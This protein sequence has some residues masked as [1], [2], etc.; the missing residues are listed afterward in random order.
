MTLSEEDRRLVGL[1]AAD[2]AER[3]LPLFEAKAPSDTRPRE[4]IEG[5]RAYAR[6]G[7]R[8]AQL[9]SF[10][11]AAHAAAREVDDP[12]ATAAARAASLAAAT[13][14][15]HAL[16]TPHQAKHALG[17][18]VYGAR[19]RELAAV[20]EPSVGDEE[21]RWAIEHASPAVREVVQRMPV[22]GPGRSRLDVLL[23]RLDSGLRATQHPGQQVAEGDSKGTPNP[24]LH[25]AAA[26]RLSVTH[27]SLS[28]RG[29]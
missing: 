11:W 28:R 4:A 15:M 8:T 27:S 29:R 10:A 22:R 12:V 14:Y 19:A 1:L 26:C 7:K 17:P 24:A 13:A 5:I 18:V 2:C 16:V 9:R 6:G 3:V 23:Y 21:I 20:D 25:L